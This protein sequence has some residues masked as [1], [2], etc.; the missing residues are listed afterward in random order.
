MARS[1]VSVTGAK[2][3]TKMISDLKGYSVLG[4]KN[5]IKET[6]ELVKNRYKRNVKR[7][8]KTGELEN[9]IESEFEDFGL[10]AIVGSDADHALF[11]E[12]GTKAHEIRVRTAS[13]LSDGVDFFGKVVN[14]P[15]TKANDGLWRAFKMYVGTNGAKLIK[16]LKKSAEMIK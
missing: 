3:V 11:I 8:K 15:G 2:E 12:K 14:H 13:V 9:S 4:V 10:T 6:A 16:R 7:H 5:D 1:G